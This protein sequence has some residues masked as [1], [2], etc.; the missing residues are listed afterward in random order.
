MYPV[1]EVVSLD[2]DA[3]KSHC[4]THSRK[5]IIVA[6]DRDFQWRTWIEND[7]YCEPQSLR[8]YGC[9]SSRVRAPNS[10]VGSNYWQINTVEQLPSCRDRG[11][12]ERIP[13]KKSVRSLF[14][15]RCHDPFTIRTA[16]IYV[17][18]PLLLSRTSIDVSSDVDHSVKRKWPMIHVR[19]LISILCLIS[20]LMVI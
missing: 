13:L 15:S 17:S 9:V 8:A 4:P 6:N 3:A 10:L 20:W 1:F 7:G 2:N 19:Y 12:R 18:T 11:P 14:S 5:K 16:P